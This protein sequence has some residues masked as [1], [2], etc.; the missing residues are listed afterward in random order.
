MNAINPFEHLQV[1]LIPSQYWEVV[2]YEDLHI[3]LSFFEMRFHRVTIG[4]LDVR[5]FGTIVFSIYLSIC[6]F[7]EL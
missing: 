2:S 4:V 3:M 7:I 5:V 1:F 6:E